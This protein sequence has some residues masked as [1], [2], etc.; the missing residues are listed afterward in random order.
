MDQEYQVLV[1]PYRDLRAPFAGRPI[2][3]FAYTFGAPIVLVGPQRP[4]QFTV[5]PPAALLS[6]ELQLDQGR[7]T[8]L[9]P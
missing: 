2:E 1:L 5:N 4:D 7:C 9:E 3:E 8:V 6:L